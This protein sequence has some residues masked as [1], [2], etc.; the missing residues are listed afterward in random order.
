MTE[1]LHTHTHT[2]SQAVRAEKSKEENQ[3]SEK[4][5]NFEG[6]F[7]NIISSILVANN[8]VIWFIYAVY[9]TA[10]KPCEV[11]L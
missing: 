5:E 2:F 7:E 6:F 1:W 3:I 9:K 10:E 8:S 11:G 4:T